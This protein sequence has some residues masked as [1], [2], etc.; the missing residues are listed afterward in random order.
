M[1][2]ASCAFYVNNVTCVTTS[3]SQLARVRNHCVPPGQSNFITFPEIY[4]QYYIPEFVGFL[5]QRRRWRALLQVY[6]VM[7]AGKELLTFRNIFLP[8]LH[9]LNV[10]PNETSNIHWR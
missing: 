7:S 6:D 4:K 9:G 10:D 1:T 5:L 8:H 2:H 3:Y